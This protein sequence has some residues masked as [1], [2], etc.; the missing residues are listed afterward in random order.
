ME[1]KRYKYIIDNS[2]DSITLINRDYVYEL[3]NDTYCEDTNRCQEEIVGHTVAD[4]WG[5]EKFEETIKGYID[6]C[7]SGENVNY[8]EEFSFGPFLKYMHISYY[9]Y[10]EDGEI[11]HAIVF[12]HDI[13]HIGR[14]ESKLNHYEYRDPLTGL[15]NRRSLD[16]VLDRELERAQRSVGEDLRVLLFVQ[17]EHIEKAIELYGQDIGDL[18]LENTGVRLQ[19]QLRASD[20]VFR[21][22]GRQ[23]AV[24]LSKVNNK[25]DAGRTAKKIFETVTLPYNFKGHDIVLKCA[26]GAAVYPTDGE[27]KDELIQ[28]ATSAMLETVRNGKT[29]TL[30]NQNLYKQAIRRIEIE[31]ASHRALEEQQFQLYYQPIV[32]QYFHIVGAEALLR[33][34]HPELGSIS[35]IEFIPIAEQSDLIYS[36]GK[37]IMFTVCKRLADWSRQYGIYVSLNLSSRE[38]SSSD[39]IDN[40]KA[41]L[42]S[43]QLED[44]QF[45]KFE[46][47]ESES[48]KNIDESIERILALKQLGIEVFIDDFGTGNSSLQYLKKLPARVLKIDREF[49]KEIDSSSEER[50]FLDHIVH[51]AYARG[52]KVLIEGVENLQQADLLVNIGCKRMQGFYFSKPVK[53]EEFEKLLQNGKAL[54]N[55]PAD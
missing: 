39:L 5:R 49:V 55:L 17:V 28:K 15:F 7:F 29:F 47:T 30:Y 51:M 22:D 8:V 3:A 1:E 44:P 10:Y 33:W 48:V 46:I 31:S 40:A 16:I 20:Y 24:L 23:F 50:E 38:F 45:L 6:R 18:L 13:T 21:Y 41:A 25:L 43:A 36:I 35:P 32:D 11:T 53:V 2:K 26:I 14:L 9:P 34:E 52:K 19:S 54:P 12:S 42:K 4:V 27:V 37:W